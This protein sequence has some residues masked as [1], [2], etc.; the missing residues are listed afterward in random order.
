M[1]YALA[2]HGAPYAT[3]AAVHALSFAEAALDQGHTIERIFFFHE[4]VY[5]GLNGQIPP[6]DTF[7][8]NLLKRWQALAERNVELALCIASAIKRGVLDDAEQTRY[9]QDHPTLAP[10]FELVGLGQL[11]AAINSADRYLEFPT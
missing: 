5:Q 8:Q 4:G 1:K 2:V 3:Q 9:E 7:N 6:Q 10:G 11:V